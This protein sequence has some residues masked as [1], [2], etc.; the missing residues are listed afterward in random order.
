VWA[1]FESPEVQGLTV[2]ARDGVHERARPFSSWRDPHDP[3]QL[4]VESFGDSILE[5]RPAEIPL[6]ESV[7]NMRVLDQVRTAF[8]S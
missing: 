6:S 8:S 7:S 2:V 4:M 1:S 3:Y 5:G